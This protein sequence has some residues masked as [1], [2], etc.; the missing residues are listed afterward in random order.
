[1]LLQDAWTTTAKQRVLQ[2]E[3]HGDYILAFVGGTM[4]PCLFR[5]RYRIPRYLCSMLLLTVHQ[6]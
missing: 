2:L 5:H 4:M 1:M 6:M 3:A